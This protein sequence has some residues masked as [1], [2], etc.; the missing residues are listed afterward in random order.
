MQ[1]NQDV[2]TDPER[3]AIHFQRML[4]TKQITLICLAV[5]TLYTSIA[6]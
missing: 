2:E 5:I 1:S 6:F 3:S 4:E